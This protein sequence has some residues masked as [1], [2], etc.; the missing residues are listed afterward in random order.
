MS[1]IC[2]KCTANPQEKVY[3][4]AF[5]IDG[6]L[7]LGSPAGRVTREMLDSC[8][9]IAVLGIVSSR[10]DAPDIAKDLELDFGYT[11][12][13]DALRTV[14]AQYPNK[15]A[16]IHVADQYID[17]LEA[18]QAGWDFFY[19]SNFKGCYTWEQIRRINATRAVVAV[20]A[21]TAFFMGLWLLMR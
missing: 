4:I 6:T 14:K 16:Y 5:D 21:I 20:S 8:R 3:V 17:Q 11:G 19:V 15:Q 2:P 1:L 10:A 13:A 18:E 12:G 7:W 9:D